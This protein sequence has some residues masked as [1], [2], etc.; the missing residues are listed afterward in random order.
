MNQDQ[1]TPKPK[2]ATKQQTGGGWMRRLVERFFRHRPTR[3][4]IVLKEQ[5]L[6]RVDA[7]NA[8]GAELAALREQLPMIL[9]ALDTCAVAL[10]DHGHEWTEGER[11]IYENAVEI[12]TRESSLN[13]RTLATQP[14]P[15]MPE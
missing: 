10:A 6:V 3:R 7:H 2:R 11:A 12:L 8:T 9:G 4:E 15:Q 13:D 5:W 1:A 14:A